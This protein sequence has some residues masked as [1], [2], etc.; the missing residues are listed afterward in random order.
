MVVRNRTGL[1]CAREGW[2]SKCYQGYIRWIKSI[3]WIYALFQSFFLVVKWVQITLKNNLDVIFRL[4][5]SRLW[6]RG[7][8]SYQGYFMVIYHYD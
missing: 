8:L 3:K 1:L 6:S 4:F 7:I 2:E 5:A